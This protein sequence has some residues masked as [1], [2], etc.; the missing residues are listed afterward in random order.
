MVRDFKYRKIISLSVVVIMLFSLC[1]C[2]KKVDVEYY[3]EASGTASSGG[4]S[5]SLKEQ[6]GAEDKWEASF[7]SVGRKTFNVNAEV[8]IPD[9]NSVSVRKAEAITFTNEEKEDIIQGLKADKVYKNDD[10]YKTKE[11][12]Q[13]LLDSSRELL[14][15][16]ETDEDREFWNDVI[17]QNEAM[18]E[19]APDAPVAASDYD[20]LVY[21]IIKGGA[22]YN[23]VFEYDDTVNNYAFY[24]IR[25]NT[26]VIDGYEYM[27]YSVPANT[28]YNAFGTNRCKL[29][30]EEL[31]KLACDFLSDLGF[32]GFKMTSCTDLEVELY[33]IGDDEGELTG[34]KYYDGA[35]VVLERQVEGVRVDSDRYF[36]C[37]PSYVDS[38]AYNKALENFPLSLWHYEGES[39][40]MEINE[41]GVIRCVYTNPTKILDTQ[42]ENVKI[43]D[44]SQIQSLYEATL[45]TLVVDADYPS[46]FSLKNME[47]LY[48]KLEDPESVN[49]YSIVPVWR[50]G[51][52]EELWIM[53]N[54]IDG[55]FIS[56]YPKLY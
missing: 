1:S 30:E 43:L 44:Y 53:L 14:N 37:K 36:D 8:E 51:T 18:L 17:A 6:I 32:E 31:E 11:Y 49:H 2:G 10:E 39:V 27:L 55:S 9:V 21:L 5:I 48:Y 56:V 52:D 29:T 15:K 38:E 45:K 25:D 20:S 3:T 22:E 26:Q 34:D 46:E 16:S 19:K 23:V 33:G 28:K 35:Y 24:Y 50:L 7:H 13:E 54:A 40:K 12:W 4:G 47:L 41:T 42:A